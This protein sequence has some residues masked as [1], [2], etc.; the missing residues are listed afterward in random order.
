MKESEALCKDFKFCQGFV[1]G[2]ENG[3]GRWAESDEPGKFVTRCIV[4][5][6]HQWATEKHYLLC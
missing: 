5:R 2:S 6:T 4:R 3:L 1:Y